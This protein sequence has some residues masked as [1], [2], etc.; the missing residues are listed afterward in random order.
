MK[1]SI[2]IKK[3]T[4]TESFKKQAIQLADDLGNIAEACR[5]LGVSK[6]NIRDWK[7]AMNKKKTNDTQIG[8]EVVDAAL[9]KKLEKEN[10]QLRLENEILKKATAYF[11]ADHLKQ[12][13]HG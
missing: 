11:A 1:S 5:Q 8:S 3:R 6:S 4:F 13:T 2:F 10:K 9:L 12:S 7:M